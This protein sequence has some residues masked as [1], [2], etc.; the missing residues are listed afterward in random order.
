MISSTTASPLRRKATFTSPTSPSNQGS[1]DSMMNFTR[2][3]RK[4]SASLPP[5]QNLRKYV[6]TEQTK[7]NWREKRKVEH[8]HSEEIFN[9]TSQSI[10]GGQTVD[11]DCEIRKVPCNLSTPLM[12]ALLKVLQLEGILN[13]QDLLV[14]F[15]SIVSESQLPCFKLREGTILSGLHS[16]EYFFIEYGKVSK[17]N[18]NLPYMDIQEFGY[19]SCFIFDCWENGVSYLG[20]E[21]SQLWIVDR[22]FMAYFMKAFTTMQLETFLPLIESTAAFSGLT[23][24]QIEEIAL[25]FRPLD[26][27]TLKHPGN[28]IY[29]SL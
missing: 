28:N 11:E 12:K 13:E 1:S 29:K 19:H 23:R 26:I 5:N 16:D 18:V 2:R 20:I 22:G 3:C 7:Q 6:P 27:Q 25:H 24:S 17:Q 10:I 4:K 21:D 14:R 15:N 9:M 8:K